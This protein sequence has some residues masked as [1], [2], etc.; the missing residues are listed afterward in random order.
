MH[1]SPQLHRINAKVKEN[2]SACSRYKFERSVTLTSSPS[3]P[4]SERAALPARPA[5]GGEEG[6]GDPGGRDQGRDL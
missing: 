2:N 1:V 3:S 5:G 6:E 4:G